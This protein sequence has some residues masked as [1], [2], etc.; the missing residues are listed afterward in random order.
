M[1]VCSHSHGSLSFH[2]LC[3]HLF[4]VYFLSFCG[5]Q[6]SEPVCSFH[7]VVSILYCR[8]G[9]GH[10]ALC[11]WARLFLLAWLRLSAE[12]LLGKC[13][14]SL[15][16][17]TPTLA[18]CSANEIQIEIFS[19]FSDTEP[20]SWLQ[21][22]VTISI[23]LQD[24]VFIPAMPVLTHPANWGFVPWG[25]STYVCQLEN[26]AYALTRIVNYSKHTSFHMKGRQIFNFISDLQLKVEL[27]V[28]PPTLKRSPQIIFCNKY[29]K[30]CIF[31][32]VVCFS[33]ENTGLVI[34]HGKF[35]VT[36]WTFLKMSKSSFTNTSYI[37][38]AP[39]S[40]LT[41]AQWSLCNRS[42]KS[43]VSLSALLTLCWFTLIN[44]DSCGRTSLWNTQKPTVM[45][46]APNSQAKFATTWWTYGL[47]ERGR[48]FFQKW[49]ED[50]TVNGRYR[51]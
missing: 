9:S 37:K 15:D 22:A 39:L 25:I 6:T 48:C 3:V 13:G 8:G 32:Q 28:F 50:K 26:L 36:E 34:S 4:S 42:F 31:Q 29:W 12:A 2:V 27:I 21:G 30:I 33:V 38:N 40:V 24:D 7:P 5:Q 1:S 35:V 23:Y 14:W 19:Q 18:D 16:V 49:A 46:S 10:W 45:W 47:N 44:I 11:W 51:T 43:V 41:T 20:P 17:F